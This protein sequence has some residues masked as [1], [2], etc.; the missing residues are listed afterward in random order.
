[1]DY[2]DYSIPFTASTP[3]T[4]NMTVYAKWVQQQTN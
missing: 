4:G 3:V 1:M 2:E